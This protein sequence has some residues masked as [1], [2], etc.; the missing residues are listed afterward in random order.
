MGKGR[1]EG[2]RCGL[3]HQGQDRADPVLGTQEMAQGRPIV[4]AALK[5]YG[6][7]AI[8]AD[9]TM[10]HLARQHMSIPPTIAII[11][12]HAEHMAHHRSTSSL[13]LSHQVTQT[14]HSWM[15][16]RRAG[17]H[18]HR[19]ALNQPAPSHVPNRH[20]GGA[21]GSSESLHMGRPF[22]DKI[23]SARKYPSGGAALPTALD[24]V[25]VRRA[26]VRV[27]HA[28]VDPKAVLF[29]RV[30]VGIERTPS[31]VRA[32]GRGRR[33][34]VSDEVL[35]DGTEAGDVLLGLDQGW[36]VRPAAERGP[37]QLNQIV[38]PEAD[39]ADVVGAGFALKPEVSAARTSARDELRSSAQS[40]C[41]VDGMA[42]R[43]GTPKRLRQ[44]PS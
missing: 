32:L 27:R 26:I 9:D 12:C 13:P 30:T 17:R 42:Q 16:F 1:H 2:R 21:A 5:R 39:A 34:N 31:R 23:R 24:P 8:G 35:L 3:R 11:G 4:V 40:A 19:T 20:I 33:A 6:T 43:A 25:V 18:P 41:Q 29:N 44:G 22:W 36:P 10:Q 7:I 15:V 38:L 37:A 28:V 14:G